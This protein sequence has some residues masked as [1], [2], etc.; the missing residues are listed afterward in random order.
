MN[1]VKTLFLIEANPDVD[2]FF[3]DWINRGY[4]AEVLFKRV[5][6]P[7]RALRRLWL[8]KGLLKSEIWYGDWFKNLINYDTIIIHMSKLTRYMPFIIRKKYP[9]IRIIGW[10]WNT[11]DNNTKPIETEDKNIEYYSFDENDCIEYGLKKNIQYYCDPL[12]LEKRTNKSDI[13]FIG[14]SKG[15]KEKIQEI[16]RICED[17]KLKCDFN[18]IEDSSNDII[19]YSE[20]K[21]KLLE[22]KSIL[23]IN[24]KNQIGYTLRA[25]ESLFYEIKL[26]TDNKYIKQAPFYNKD[27]IFIVDE[28][29]YVNLYDFI[30]KPY[31]HSVDKYKKEYDL[32]RWFN[33]FSKE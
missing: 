19:P 29:E 5:N 26:I 21:K 32:D 10:Y 7:L 12:V 23:E 6:K 31:N 25:L 16:K 3:N 1:K 28:D 24:K 22:T 17:N 18:V 11:I 8:Q 27:N 20:V 2:I 4:K 14:R 33:N 9:N 30:N 15:R 13:Y